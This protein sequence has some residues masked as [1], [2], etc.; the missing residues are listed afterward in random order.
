MPAAPEVLLQVYSSISNKKYLLTG[1]I[2]FSFNLHI[3]AVTA[4][5][6]ATAAQGGASGAPRVSASH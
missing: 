6:S 2:V 1:P 4:N 3:I 5:I